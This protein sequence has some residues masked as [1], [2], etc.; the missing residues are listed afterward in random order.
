[1]A[2]AADLR[3]QL[4][5]PVCRG[6]YTDPVMLPC[7][8]NFCRGCT[9]GALGAPGGSG[10]YSCPECRA[11]YEGPP[12][13]PRNRTL[14]NIAGWFRAAQ[15]DPGENGIPC[16]YC[17]CYPVPAAQSCLQCQAS[18]CG[19]HLQIHN[20]ALEHSLIRPIAS[21]QSRKCSVHNKLLEY[22]CPRDGAC[23]C[24]SCCL[25]PEHRG[26]KVEPL[27]E[28]SE[29]KKE[30]LRKVLEKLSPEREETEGQIQN[31]QERRREVQEK[32]A[33]VTEQINALFRDIRERLSLL[34][35]QL[36]IQLSM[37]K[38]I[39]SLQ[40]GDLIRELEIKKDEMS[41]KIRHIEELCNM[42]DPLAVLQEQ[43]E[44][45]GA[46]T[47]GREEGDT[48]G[49]DNEG[50]VGGDTGGADNEGRVEG[51][52]EGADNE[53]RVEGDTEGADNEGRVEGDTEGADNEGRVEG[54][55]EG[56]DNE[57]RVEGDTEGAYNESRVEGDTEGADNEGRVEG[58]TE[59]A[60]NESRVEGDTEG[61]DNEGRVE[62]D[63]EGADNDSRVVDTEGADN[64][65]RVVDT[66][67]ADNRGRER[68]DMKV[69]VAVGDVDV[70]QISETLLTGLAGIV[71]WV[72]RWW[73][74]GEEATDLVL[75]PITAA[76]DVSVSED[77]KYVCSSETTQFHPVGPGRFESYQVLST[78]SFSSGRHYWDMD[79]SELW[80]WFVGVA[81]PSIDRGGDQS[82]IGNNKKSWHLGLDLMDDN[83]SVRHDWVDTELPYSPSCWRIRVFLDYEAGR[84]SFYEL[85]EPIRH[86]HTFSASFTEPLHAAFC[87]GRGW[88]RIIS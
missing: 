56:A 40:L 49:A 57:G 18:L 5:C 73:I 71:T 84:L 46:D 81:Y 12:D 47:G 70:E 63:T 32:A 45:E 37:Q 60:D 72:R 11:E 86:L 64:V 76:N 36:H 68:D 33:G 16:T 85:S 24:S 44:S 80:G 26:H 8:H 30:K 61:A 3:D 83:Y 54:D 48:E 88:V 7:G 55:T 29:K 42:A 78:R 58:D 53:G 51:D 74:S 21:F 31:L 27:S 20:R 65:G 38:V 10:G 87:I 34:E 52:T 1:M 41:R 66:E 25:A 2:S 43:R 59:G 14:G 50:R 28:A 39:V 82:I 15:P 77:R 35:E 4:T 62:G 9:G 23:M 13:L 17:I 22:Y 6:I 75:D 67:G 19:A 69:P 79:V